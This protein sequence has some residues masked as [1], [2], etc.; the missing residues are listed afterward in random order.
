MASDENEALKRA[1]RLLE[2]KAPVV[3]TK[4]EP[5]AN[6]L[7]DSLETAKAFNEN[8]SWLRRVG[9][10]MSFCWQKILGVLGVVW[11]YSG[12]MRVIIGPIARFIGRSYKRFFQWSVYKRSRESGEAVF[13]KKR[14]TGVIL[15][16]ALIPFAL[17]YGTKPVLITVQQAM[18]ALI[19]EKEVYTYFHGA[20]TIDEGKLYSIKTTSRVPATPE[21]TMHMHV[22][23]DL[24]YWIWYPEDLANAVPNEVAWGRVKYTGWRWKPFK[25]FPEVKDVEAIPLSELPAGHPAKSGNYYLS[26]EQVRQAAESGIALPGTDF[27]AEQD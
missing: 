24:V 19:A 2:K 21:S 12:P 16:T 25:W 10:R 1:R 4:R 26:D 9:R 6:A 22:Q 27:G 13:S 5:K 11:S 14:A 18:M 23:Q 7:K 15:L 20:E 3:S 17:W 8:V